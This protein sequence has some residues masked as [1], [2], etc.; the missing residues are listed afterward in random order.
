MTEIT[1]SAANIFWIGVAV[2]AVSMLII[3]VGL[4]AYFGTKS[5]KEKKGEK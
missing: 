3:G 4:A 1:L 2:G 5:D